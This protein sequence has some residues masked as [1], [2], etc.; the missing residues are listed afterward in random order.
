MMNA[1]SLYETIQPRYPEFKGQVALITGSSRGIGKGIALRL[2]REGMKVVLHGYDAD[3]LAGTE[4]EFSAL[5]VDV[6]ALQSDFS[7]PDAADELIRFT[8]DKFGTLDLLVN[9]AADLRR[10]KIFEDLPLLDHQLAVNLRTPYVLAER[11]AELMKPKKA[12]NIVSISS[13]GGLRSHWDGLP[14]DVTKGAIDAMT[15]TMAIELAHLGIRVNAVAPGAIAVDRTWPPDPELIRQLSTRIPLERF[16]TPLEIGAAVA[17]LASPDASYITG[18]I[19]Y[20]D[21]GLTTQLS[22]RPYPI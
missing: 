13:V 17:Y 14:Y 3:E 21:A 8:V 4:A 10:T 20:V 19:L 1:A 2:A 9:N 12:G 22:P 7:L 15:R 5:G 11:A 18:Q 6:A 16:G